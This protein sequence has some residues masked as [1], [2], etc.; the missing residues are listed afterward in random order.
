MPMRA[1]LTYHSI[2]ASGSVISVSPELFRRQI[3]WLARSGIRVV[4]LEALVASV[5]PSHAERFQS[6][7]SDRP[8]DPDPEPGRAGE[9]AVTFDDAFANF[10]SDAWPVLEAH[11]VPVTVFVPAA[12]VGGVNGWETG[13]G[14]A[15]V[16][17]LMDWTTLS[18]LAARGVTIGSH[19]LQ[20]PDLRGMTDAGLEE[21]V[22]GSAE[23]IRRE[24]GR[25]VHTFA[26]PY[27][28]CDDR[29]VRTVRTRYKAAVTTEFRTLHNGEDPCRLP[30]LDM[31]YF[32]EPGRLESWG[33]G[34]FR[35][36]ITV[37]R[38]LRRV[39][40][41]FNRGRKQ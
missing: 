5:R 9:V 35:R 3:E 28:A 31:Y 32:R 21:E 13:S 15:P 25:E 27:G 23:W 12:H 8:G 24:T 20:H 38:R 2:D 19:G 22:A 37:R 1:I 11:G 36:Y 39:R 18:E 29:V 30:R 17:P 41:F 40:G 4:R 26:Y 33:T 34:A 14:G 16:L 6:D 10:A 7:A